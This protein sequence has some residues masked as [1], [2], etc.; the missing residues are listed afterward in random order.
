MYLEEKFRPGSVT[1][2]NLAAPGRSA[3]TFMSEGRWT[4]ALAEKPDYVFIQFGHNDSHNPANRES[5][6]PAGDFREFLRRYITEARA[7]GAK[8]ILVTP[9]V[10]RNFDGQ[11]KIADSAPPDRPL[12]AYA[13][14]MMEVGRETGVPVIDL[15]ASSL[16]L[17][18]K[19]GLK[20][21][22][23]FAS[24]RSDIT[25]FN[26]KGARAMADLVVAEISTAAPALGTLLAR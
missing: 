24:K 17:N 19:L 5:T 4:K 13:A 1:V 14:A 2:R 7:A 25:H 22:A 21:S 15:H 9:M 8:P 6:D 26:E 18:E 12:S 16:A 11:G 10:R 3:K 20:A 23:G